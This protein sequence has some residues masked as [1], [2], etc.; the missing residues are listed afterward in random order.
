M[1]TKS[2]LLREKKEM[3]NITIMQKT[4]KNKYF[5]LLSLTLIPLAPQLLWSI[6]VVLKC[7]V[8]ERMT[9]MEAGPTSGLYIRI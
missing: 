2:G 1:P 7:V 8:R 9:G 6:K 4:K 3:I 5:F